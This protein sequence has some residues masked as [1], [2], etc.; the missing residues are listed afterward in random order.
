MLLEF[1]KGLIIVVV[2]QL[3]F[4]SLFLFTQK[5]HHKLSNRL[6]AVFFLL[7]AINFSDLLL[8]LMDLDGHYQKV[9]LLDDA[10]ILAFGPII[11][12]YTQSL[13]SGIHRFPRKWIWHYLPFMLVTLLYLVI[14]M[15]L[16][17]DQHGQMLEDIDNAQLPLYIVVITILMQLH[18]LVYLLSAYRS[19]ARYAQVVKSRFS[20]LKDRNPHWIGFVLRSVL[21][22][23][24]VSLLHATLPIFTRSNFLLPTVMLLL[25]A[26]L[27]F[28]N[29]WIWKA[30]RSSYIIDTSNELPKYS[31]SRLS[32]SDR[33][34]YKNRLEKS[35]QE[36]KH[37]LNADLTIDDL[38]K[39][40]SIAPKTLSQVINQS[41]QLNFY[42]FINQYRI[43]E[44]KVL[45]EETPDSILSILFQCGYN[46]KSSFNT[47]FKKYTGTTPSDYRKSHQNGSSS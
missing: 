35:L 5:T 30:L 24:L 45:L 4:L 41:Y 25:I 7:M 38:S 21:F 26:V 33:L 40:L 1:G 22:L 47:F 14:S 42:E 18:P 9:A 13:I 2:A 46:S 28:V 43:K 34:D 3:L 15:L 6:L 20:N 8:K 29:R 32:E 11:W 44:A 39:E 10:F 23:M 37:F 12:Q 36:Q 17:A 27:F 19:V 16:P 31:G